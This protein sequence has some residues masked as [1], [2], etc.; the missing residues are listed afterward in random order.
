MCL[1]LKSWLAYDQLEWYFIQE[2]R[3]YSKHMVPGSPALVT[4][5]QNRFPKF[6]R[7]LCQRKWQSFTTLAR[8]PFFEPLNFVRCQ[9][10]CEKTLCTKCVCVCVCL[11]ATV[12]RSISA[13]KPE[14]GENG[15]QNAKTRTPRKNS[16]TAK[17]R[18][19]ENSTFIQ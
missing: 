3:N 13:R 4:M 10:T 11:S 1:N 19:T 14:K 16:K 9:R 17:T 15:Q 6:G 5:L 12:M 18:K 2:K 7:C 8:P